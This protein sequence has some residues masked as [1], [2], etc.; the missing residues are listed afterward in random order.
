MVEDIDLG[1]FFELA[2]TDKRYSNGLNLHQIKSKV[3]SDYTG[4]FELIC[5][6]VRSR[7]RT[8]NKYQ[9]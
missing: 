1:R 6:N 8:K 5:K 7:D 9:I 4:D 2:S 3:L